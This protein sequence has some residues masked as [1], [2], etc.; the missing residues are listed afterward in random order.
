MFDNW[1]DD[2]D[3]AI[4]LEKQYNHHA[5][6]LTAFVFFSSAGFAEGQAGP[7]EHTASL[8]SNLLETF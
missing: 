5:L 6:L 1:H 3:I 2:K 7:H 4:M 8:P